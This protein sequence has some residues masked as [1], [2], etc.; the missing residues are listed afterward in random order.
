MT[1]YLHDRIL[2]CSSQILF[3]PTVCVASSLS[4]MTSLLEMVARDSED[5]ISDFRTLAILS[6]PSLY[7]LFSRCE[8]I[9]LLS[10]YDSFSVYKLIC[11]LQLAFIVMISILW[12]EIAKFSG[13]ATG[14]KISVTAALCWLIKLVVTDIVSRLLWGPVSGHL[15]GVQVH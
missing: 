1:W 9:S 6:E 13:S 10:L 11:R 14:V 3:R 4:C 15:V 8:L 7:S 5:W 12:S 2:F